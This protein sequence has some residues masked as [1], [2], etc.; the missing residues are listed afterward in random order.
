MSDWHYWFAYPLL[1]VHPGQSHPWLMHGVVQQPPSD[2]S[3]QHLH[4]KPFCTLWFRG[5][6]L[7]DFLCS[8]RHNPRPPLVCVCPHHSKLSALPIH[9]CSSHTASLDTNTIMCLRQETARDFGV[10][11]RLSFSFAR[12]LLLCVLYVSCSHCL[13]LNGCFLLTHGADL[14]SV[15]TSHTSFLRGP[16]QIIVLS[17]CPHS[18]CAGFYSTK[19]QKFPLISLLCTF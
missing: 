5:R 6:S 9:V 14:H 8:C 16:A 15:I 10:C 4:H 13:L 7:S 17:L 11:K 19:P 18:T 12:P 1:Y 2:F 3:H